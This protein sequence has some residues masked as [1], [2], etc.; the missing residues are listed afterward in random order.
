MMMTE[1]IVI[2]TAEWTLVFQ[3]LIM[4]AAALMSVGT[5]IAM[6]YPELWLSAAV[7]ENQRSDADLQKFHPTAAP[8]AGSTNLVAWRMK[9]PVR[10]MNVVIS[11]VV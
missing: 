11:P 9:P 3:N 8:S 7:S 6:V 2:H 1:N 5:T 4:V 10:G